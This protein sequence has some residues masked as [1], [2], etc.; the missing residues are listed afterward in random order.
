MAVYFAPNSNALAVS[1]P[2]AVNI[3]KT[4]LSGTFLQPTGNPVFHAWINSAVPR[5]T[6]ILYNVV[7]FNDGNGY[8]PATG[9]FT[10][11]VAGIYHLKAELVIGLV[12]GEYRLFLS[13]NGRTAR[14][15][16]FYQNYTNMN[17]SLLAEGVF[18]MAKGDYAY[19]S[20]TGPADAPTTAANNFSG[21]F[22]G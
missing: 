5:S 22:V 15:T 13:S 2:S 18:N 21:Y 6:T 7:N 14:Q 11:P 9:I 16:I 3:A 17:H 8:N 4:S 19:V 20:A 10:A 1:S 12:Q